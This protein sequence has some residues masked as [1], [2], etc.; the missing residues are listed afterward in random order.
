MTA[1]EVA[2]EGEET[3]NVK[4]MRENMERQATELTELRGF[5]RGVLMKDA[6]LD[7]STG[8]GKAVAKDIERGDYEGE[9]TATALQEYAKSE[10]AWELGAAVETTTVQEAEA[11][12]VAE[13]V[14]EGTEKLAE[15]Q[16]AGGPPGVEDSADRANAAGLEKDWAKQILEGTTVTFEGM[17]DK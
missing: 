12:A 9:M 11:A 3:E 2:T 1:R 4:Q 16:T 17:K 10:Y 5:K 15:V 7:P 8:I 13:V 6:A 14:T